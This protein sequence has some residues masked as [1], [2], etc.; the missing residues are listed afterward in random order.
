MHP[1][2]IH[3]QDRSYR[4]GVILGLTMAEI[5]ILILFGLLLLLTAELAQKDLIIASFGDPQTVEKMAQQLA[6]STAQITALE[7]QIDQLEP[8]AA[9]GD[10]VDQFRK[11]LADAG[12]SP[13]MMDDLKELADK[14]ALANTV[15]DVAAGTGGQA[16]PS[17]NDIKDM[18]QSA[19]EAGEKI[20]NLQGQNSFLSERL[21]SLGKGGN[22]FPPCW[23]TPDGHVEYIFDILLNG[24]NVV[25][26][27]NA[28]PNRVAEEARLPLSGIEFQKQADQ[29]NFTHETQPLFDWSKNENCRF[30]VRIRSADRTLDKDLFAAVTDHFYYLLIRK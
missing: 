13:D 16:K 24:T 2:S 28:L 6:G 15:M 26:N 5:L 23:A 11:T 7:Q 18:L 21:K 14:I 17:A 8:L 29:T 19:K 25:V 12:L 9:K 20:S 4:R 22:E 30:Y 10:K 1:D 27:D 3:Q